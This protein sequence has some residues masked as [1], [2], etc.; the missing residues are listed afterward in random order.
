MHI[1]DQIWNSFDK[2]WNWMGNG[3]VF[4]GEQICWCA[5][6]PIKGITRRKSWSL[7]YYTE[8]VPGQSRL[9][10][11]R[12]LAK[13][14]WLQCPKNSRSMIQDA[15]ILQCEACCWVDFGYADIGA[16]GFLFVYA[17][18]YCLSSL[19]NCSTYV[20]WLCMFLMLLDF[21]LW[22]L[23]V[24]ESLSLDNNK[25]IEKNK[26]ER[27]ERKTEQWLKEERGTMSKRKVWYWMMR[28]K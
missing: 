15:M 14:W 12:L 16:A 27:E 20:S 19:M 11:L 17:G 26:V 13:E 9:F 5:D 8:V 22:F 2:T 6:P 24:A 21:V 4:L 1:L 25:V 10:C 28:I 3:R 18:F 7:C 23:Y